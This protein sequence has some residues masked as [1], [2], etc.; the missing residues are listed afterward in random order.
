MPADAEFAKKIIKMRVRYVLEQS[1]GQ[2]LDEKKIKNIA[3]KVRQ[4]ENNR[5]VADEIKKLTLNGI[6]KAKPLLKE[7]V[8]QLLDEYAQSI[9]EIT[10]EAILEM[11]SGEIQKMAEKQSEK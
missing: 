5:A 6:E 1:Q 10:D 3:D 8:K 9:K 7:V 11:V 2:I 4:G